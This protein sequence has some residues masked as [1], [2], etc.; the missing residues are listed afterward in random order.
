MVLS[1]L[2]HSLSPSITQSILWIDKAED[3]WKDL[4]E[5][6][7]QEDV[8]RISDLQEEIYS[9]KQGEKSVSDYF[10]DLK[11]LWDEL[12]NFRPIPVCTCLSPCNCGV[13][14][15][16]RQYQERDYVVRFLKGLKDSFATVKLQIMLIDPFPNINRAFS[17]VLQH[18]RRPN[19][20]IPILP[21][22]T[23]TEPKAF[24]YKTPPDNRFK[25]TTFNKFNSSRPFQ[26]PLL[27]NADTRFCTFYGKSIHT[28]ETCFKKHGFPPGFPTFKG[29]SHMVS[30]VI[31]STD[32]QTES[33]DCK[34]SFASPGNSAN[35]SIPLIEDQ[36]CTFLNLL[37]S[38][39][40]D[41]RPDNA[42][43]RHPT[44]SVDLT[45]YVINKH[46]S[47]NLISAFTPTTGIH[48]ALTCSLIKDKWIVDTGATDHIACNLS[49]SSTCYF[50]KQIPITLPNG[51]KV[52]AYIA[53]SEQ[54]ESDWY[55]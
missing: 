41:N 19:Y 48:F 17:L 33:A 54:L 51:N 37:Q 36:Y 24:A 50:I 23:F 43:Q 9:L 46:S 39:H 8:L 49:M 15:K 47:A 14:A 12:G 42:L 52:N 4:R 35:T 11:I 28:I 44:D 20:S 45:K 27:N 38:N 25:P 22:P 1:W 53:E 31:A 5:R 2:T 30:N 32:A 34:V 3:V 55:S 16:Y 13:L 26:K 10:T 6:I 29:K 18:E 21:N 40:F 7:A